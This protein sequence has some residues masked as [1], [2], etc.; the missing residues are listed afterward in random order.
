V[1]IDVG[2]EIDLNA[3]SGPSSASTMSSKVILFAGRVS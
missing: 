3:D 2:G 1:P